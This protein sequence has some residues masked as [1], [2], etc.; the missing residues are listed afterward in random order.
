M[1]AAPRM[2]RL[3]LTA[4]L[5][6]TLAITSLSSTVG[7]A[8]ADEGEIV[9]SLPDNGGLGLV[10]W[11]GGPAADLAAAARAEGCN[12]S[13]IHVNDPA[14]GSLI[15][16]LPTTVRA[17]NETFLGAFPDG[18]PA[19]TPVL[20]TCN[21][22]GE[23][24]VVFLGDVPVALQRSIHDGIDSVRSYFN[25]NFDIE[26]SDFSVYVAEGIE[27]GLPFYS[28]IRPGL[29]WLDDPYTQATAYQARDGERLIFMSGTDL[30]ADRFGEVF[31]HEYF[32]LLQLQLQDRT[33]PRWDAGPW[34]LME[35]T[36]HYA[37]D[38]YDP[39]RAVN[40][41]SERRDRL[42]L[43]LWS[44]TDALAA[45]ERDGRAQD[46]SLATIATEYLVEYSGR[47]RSY[48]HFWRSLT[49]SQSWEVAFE[50]AFGTSVHD[51]YEDFADYYASRSGWIIAELTGAVDEVPGSARLGLRE[52]REVWSEPIVDGVARA[53]VRGGLYQVRLGTTL[54][55]GDAQFSAD[56]GFYDSRTGELKACEPGTRGVE[57]TPAGIERITVEVP[58]YYR[59]Q[60][61]ISDPNGD[62][63]PWYG[64]VTARVHGLCEQY[65]V[66][67]LHGAAMLHFVVPQG[68]SFTVAIYVE[69]EFVGWYGSDGWASDA[70][71]A[72]TFTVDGSDVTLPPLRLF[73]PMISE[74]PTE[75]MEVE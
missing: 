10:L 54:M 46:Q 32:H 30:R 66:H 40:T 41:T 18:L 51:F 59:V 19:S 6:A 26:V 47:E 60:G 14:G 73:E 33:A 22:P 13:A 72:E 57:V 12:V 16:Y 69:H 4:S 9:G 24:R 62:P 67:S 68:S 39:T 61:I 45:L 25:E 1:V 44:G 23:P 8:A 2:R 7:S 74:E 29:Q 56:L 11:G 36:A 52:S 17:P 48:I 70:A 75:G 3:L 38:L 42:Q 5:F 31:A 43:A 27:H 15:R 35:G 49:D 71:S 53:R 50:D 20:V 37:D 64:G 58:R 65:A 55:S 21:R 63:V 28:E 34:W